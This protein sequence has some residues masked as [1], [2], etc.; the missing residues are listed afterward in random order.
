M[1]SDKRNSVLIKNLRTLESIVSERSGKR[2]SKGEKTEVG[3]AIVSDKDAA[4]EGLTKGL[5]A[6]AGEGAAALYERVG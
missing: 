6:D 3:V 5:G 4:S 2:L 1:I